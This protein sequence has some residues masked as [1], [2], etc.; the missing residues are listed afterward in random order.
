MADVIDFPRKLANQIEIKAW[1]L[2]H[3]IAEVLSRHHEEEQ[4][5]A[6]I[7]ILLEMFKKNPSLE[8]ALMKLLENR[9]L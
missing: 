9:R 5:V 3:E 6:V 1:I 8:P 7:G 2:N 4:F